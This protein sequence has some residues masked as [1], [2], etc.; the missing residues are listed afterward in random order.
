MDRVSGLGVG[1][2]LLAEQKAD[3]DCE[4]AKSLYLTQL[5]V[6]RAT[7]GGFDCSI[8]TPGVCSNIASIAT[9]IVI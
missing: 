1:H 9:G 7:N 2:T 6:A 3:C 5:I 4:L 8:V